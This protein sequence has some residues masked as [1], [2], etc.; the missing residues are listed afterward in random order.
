M[1]AAVL[2]EKP[3]KPSPGRPG[4]GPRLLGILI[5]TAIV[6]T[7]VG[8]LFSDPTTAGLGAV[9]AVC[10]AM[11]LPLQRRGH[12]NAVGLIA[13]CVLASTASYAMWVGYGVH[14]TATFI[15]PVVV[16]IGGMTLARR[17]FVVLLG[18]IVAITIVIG[19]G[20]WFGWLRND[21][22]PLYNEVDLVVAPI[23]L[24]D[25]RSRHPERPGGP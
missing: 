14:D 5:V 11:L 25:Q 4:L 9:N 10:Y 2:P 12:S 23:L 21:L 18:L 3:G 19:V 7:L 8:A 17:Y 20:E 16:L 6:T 24:A 15:L 22:Y 1:A 13:V